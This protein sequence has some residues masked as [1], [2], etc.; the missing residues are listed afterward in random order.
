MPI[1]PVR[2]IIKRIRRLAYLAAPNNREDGNRG[3]KKIIIIVYNCLK[4]SSNS[5]VG[6][7]AAGKD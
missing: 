3:K 4:K 7:G 2:A 5:E 6:F 1:P